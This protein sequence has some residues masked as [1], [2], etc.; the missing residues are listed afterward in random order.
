MQKRGN[1]EKYLSPKE[2]DQIKDLEHCIRLAKNK[3]DVEFYSQE[4]GKIMLGIV[5]RYREDYDK[6]QEERQQPV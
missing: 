1:L 5:D 2:R 6:R 3:E 4:I